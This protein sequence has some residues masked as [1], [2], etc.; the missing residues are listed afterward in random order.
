MVYACI[1]LI[2]AFVPVLYVQVDTFCMVNTEYLTTE[3]PLS[4]K[5]IINLTTNHFI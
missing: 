2:A 1:G 4:N 5:S 3:I